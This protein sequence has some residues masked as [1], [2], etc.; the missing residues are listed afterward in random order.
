MSLSI[1]SIQSV[2]VLKKITNG[3]IVTADSE[4]LFLPDAEVN[5]EFEVGDTI[6]VFIFPD[7]KG[8]LNATMSLPDITREAYGWAE[9]VETVPH[10]GVYVQIGIQKEILVSKDELPYIQKVWPQ[11]GDDLFVSLEVDK[12]GRLLAEPIS[13]NEVME[14][15]IK[16]PDSLL[17]EE[18]AG[19]IY[20]STKS[21]SFLLT[22]EGYRGFIH[23]HERKQEPRMGE[24]I[25]GRVIDVKE[26]GTI[27]VSLLS[28][29]QDQ[30]KD[31]SDQILA[32][33]EEQGGTM[34]FHD[35][36]SPE[37]IRQTFQISKAAFKRALGKLLK[38]DKI[39]M[40]EESTRLKK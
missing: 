3:F 21:G 5:E 13:E 14:D 6:S 11:P 33:L 19:R 22:E 40:D 36:S 30:M 26:D 8:K 18:V 25:Q 24:T 1:G 35:K 38:D 10:L 17:H 34:Y 31:D 32:F 29:K 4:E 15:L 16:A 7:K 28:V 9:V 23:P 39:V 20:K 12:K 37:D 2:E 27:N